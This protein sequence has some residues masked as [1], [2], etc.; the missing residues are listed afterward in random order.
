MMMRAMDHRT[1]ILSRKQTQKKLKQ[2]DHHAPHLLQA[3]AEHGKV[4]GEPLTDPAP[5]GAAPVLPDE[6]IC[7][8]ERSGQHAGDAG[9]G[10]MPDDTFVHEEQ[11]LKGWTQE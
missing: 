5:D 8:R 6:A 3:P 10:E 4:N 1:M 11:M 7:D 2:R 9:T